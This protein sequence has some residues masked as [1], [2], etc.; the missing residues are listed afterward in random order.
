MPRST[1]LRSLLVDEL[2]DLYFVER[3]LV[4]AIPK[5]AK[6]AKDAQLKS[7]L[8]THLAET[9]GHVKRLAEVF[10]ILKV[11]PKAR[12]CKAMVDLLHKGSEAAAQ[13]GPSDLRDANIIG[14]AQQVEHFELA[15]YGTASSF[16]EALDEFEIVQLLQATAEEE[17]GA[18]HLLTRI[19]SDV[20]RNALAANKAQVHITAA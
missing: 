3:K 20:N 9:K 16:A 2:R 18:N 11:S 15:A 6:A 13:P 17:S 5:L 12:T 10:K 1:N 7:A 8:N 19:S 14:A 4:K